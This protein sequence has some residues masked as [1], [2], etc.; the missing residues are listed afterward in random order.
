MIKKITLQNIL[1]IYYKNYNWKKKI[2]K[3]YMF[4]KKILTCYG[5]YY[6][7]YKEQ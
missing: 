3:N 2:I 7:L 1:C 5:N 6:L 4:K